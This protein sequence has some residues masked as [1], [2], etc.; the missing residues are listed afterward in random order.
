M[1]DLFGSDYDSEEEEFKA[2][3]VGDTKAIIVCLCH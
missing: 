2:S 1:E 3:Y